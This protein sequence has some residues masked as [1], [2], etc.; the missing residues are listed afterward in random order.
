MRKEKVP[1]MKRQLL[2]G[3]SILWIGAGCAT[4]PKVPDLAILYNRAAQYHG[5]D[6][7]PVIVIPGV[8]GSRL[9]EK[10][11]KVPVWGAFS[12]EFINPKKPEGA[13]LFALP[14]AEGIALEELRDNVVSVSA[15][16]RIELNVLGLPLEL[17]AYANILRT[18]G[19]GGYMDQQL[20]EAGAI[21]YGD[22]HFTCFQF[23]FDWRRSN[24]ENA[25]A[26]HEFILEKRTYLREELK[27][28]YG[29]DNASVKFDIVAHSM[30]GLITRYF[31][32]YGSQPLPHDG[33][34]PRL[35]WA[36]AEMVERVVLIGTPSGGSTEVISK[37][38]D[39]LKLGSF[40]KY[41]PAILGTFP[42]LY[43][44]MPRPRHGAF[45]DRTDPS[46]KLDNYDPAVWK[47]L[48]WGLAAHDQESVLEELLP[49][50][51]DADERRRIALDHQE[52]CL[53]H[54]R[55]FHDSLDLPAA[56]PESSSLQLFAG[57][58][59]E[60]P[61]VLGADFQTGAVTVLASGP[62][63]GTVARYSALMD[64]RVGAEWTPYLVTPIH[65]DHVTFMFRDHLGM[66]KDPMFTDNIL[67][68][69][70]E[71]PR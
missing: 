7:N 69:L 50:V 23:H 27:E 68:L 36:G 24:V 9:E 47:E 60:T 33:T 8:M 66:T 20:S 4:H 58:A 59:E 42:S 15:L 70:L 11:T 30:G 39:G 71:A 40:A 67:Y 31:L 62:G 22:G 25:K 13:R 46:R 53:K 29:V 32:R 64:E 3:I 48:G 45:V 35:T 26:L 16:D 44:L 19:V 28:R 6:R 49:E 52:K 18:L 21:D 54:A 61:L 5:V 14:M 17:N 56:L 38:R 41:S 63:D 51:S 57:D 2:L 10:E 1:A 34:M 37:L 12:G 65:W 43:E 55:Q